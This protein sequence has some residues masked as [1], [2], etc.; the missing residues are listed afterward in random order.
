MGVAPT[1]L[2]VA[3]VEGTPV[4]QC[5]VLTPRACDAVH[6]LKRPSSRMRSP[7]SKPDADVVVSD[8]SQLLVKS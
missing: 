7:G 8:L 6:R 2:L 1:K 5:K 3:D 4:A